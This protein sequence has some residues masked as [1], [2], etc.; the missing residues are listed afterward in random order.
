MPQRDVSHCTAIDFQPCRVSPSAVV[1]VRQITRPTSRFAE[2]GERKILLPMRA[3]V[4]NA[5]M[6]QTARP[7][8]ELN[9]PADL[10]PRPRR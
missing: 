10:R 3:P 5:S 1:T 7:G 4:R 2:I 9:Y 6:V 8:A